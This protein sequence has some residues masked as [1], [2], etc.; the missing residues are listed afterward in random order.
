MPRRW[1]HLENPT[2]FLVG[3]CQTLRSRHCSAEEQ[4]LNCT[5]TDTYC[6]RCGDRQASAVT[7]A[8]TALP[9][10]PS[11]NLVFR[12]SLSMVLSKVILI[13]PDHIDGLVRCMRP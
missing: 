12:T 8:G 13:F 5:A 10:R 11:R 6:R 4:R 7:T 1:T 9:K 3:N 2:A